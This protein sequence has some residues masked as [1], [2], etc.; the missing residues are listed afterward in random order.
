MIRTVKFAAS[1]AAL[2]AMAALSVAGALAAGGDPVKKIKPADQ[3][4]AEKI[5][6]SLADVGAGWKATK[7]SSTSSDPKCSYY[8]PDQS[9]LVENGHYDSP[10]F[11]RKDGSFVTST[12]GIF[13]T[14][15]QARTGYGRVVRPELPKCLGELFVKGITKPN[16]AKVVSTGV[17]AFPRYSDRS[18]AYR[19]VFSFKGPSGSIPVVL[20]VV[21]INR[22][23]VDVAMIFVGVGG[24]LP[25]SF[26][27][28]VAGKV[29]GRLG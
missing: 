27:Q 28:A 26:E 9:D 8:N 5:A 7:S 23:R 10:D 4:R 29:A 22:G 25:S 14:S 15:A 1:L 13:A 17:L 19:V 24:S 16:S 3:A 6:V 21:T 12:I 18:N 11:T 2:L 20:D